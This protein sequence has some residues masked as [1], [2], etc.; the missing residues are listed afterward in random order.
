MPTFKLR[1]DSRGNFVKLLVAFLVHD[2][3]AHD[4]SQYA[5]LHETREDADLLA[6]D[7]DDPWSVVL[8]EH[9]HTFTQP[10]HVRLPHG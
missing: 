5:G 6:S 1:G 4:V 8:E 9:G 2:H 10:R 7:V 3:V